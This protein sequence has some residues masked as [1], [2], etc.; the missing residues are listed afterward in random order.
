M[1]EKQSEDRKIE[2]KKTR[3]NA[4]PRGFKKGDTVKLP[5]GRIGIVESVNKEIVNVKVQARRESDDSPIIEQV[6]PI[7]RNQLK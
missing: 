1:H 3:E 2:F 6:E 5:D 4:S 7:H